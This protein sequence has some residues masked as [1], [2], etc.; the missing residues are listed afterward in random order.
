MKYNH[1]VF[2]KNEQLITLHIT[3]RNMSHCNNLQQFL[4]IQRV[5]T[6][7]MFYSNLLSLSNSSIK[8]PFIFFFRAALANFGTPKLAS[9]MVFLSPI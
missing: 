3:Y 4:I 9:S 2:F 6:A 5:L 7:T 8:V 1:Q